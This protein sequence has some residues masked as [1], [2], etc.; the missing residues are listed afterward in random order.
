MSR[1]MSSS[2]SDNKT[3]DKYAPVLMLN[4]FLH[5]PDCRLI[6]FS[7]CIGARNK[8]MKTR[9]EYA[10]CHKVYSADWVT[11][12]KCGRSYHSLCAGIESDQNLDFTCGTCA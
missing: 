4:E 1:E 3:E 9:C 8:P 11:C 5:G 7:I 6:Q 2:S 12:N 10:V